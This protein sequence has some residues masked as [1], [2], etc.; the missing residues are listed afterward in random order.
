M[1][2][3]TI[4]TLETERLTLRA[5][6]VCDL[7]V[8]MAFNAVSDAVSGA[9]R[10]GKTP[11][12]VREILTRDIAHWQKG[13]G[14][15]LLALGGGEVV[16]GAGLFQP[17][18]WLTHEL[19]W[20]LMPRH[21]GQGYATEASLAVIDYG[22]NVLKWPRVETFMRDD[23]TA[24]RQLALR[25]GGTVVRRETFP[26]GLARDVFALPRLQPARAP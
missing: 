12:Q 22:Y 1:T 14:M 5:P 3:L 26:D 8:Y 10:G 21:R 13:F 18:D 4:P 6:T 7:D 15:W 25:L 19:T 17:D 23:N 24:A 16:G 11:D 9:Y 20:W 2:R